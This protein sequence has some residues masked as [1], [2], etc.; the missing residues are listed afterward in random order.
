MAIREGSEKATTDRLQQ[1]RESYISVLT[2][3]VENCRWLVTLVVAE[4]AGIVAYRSNVVKKEPLGPVF[5]VVIIVLG[6]SLAAFVLRVLSARFE[7]KNFEGR[8]AGGLARMSETGRS[9]L[10]DE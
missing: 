6:L 1:V 7:R 10:K 3:T 9:I 2:S 4:M 5:A 8:S